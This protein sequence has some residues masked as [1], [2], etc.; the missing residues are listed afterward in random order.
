MFEKFARR[1]LHK[2]RSVA[3]R[4]EYRY[5]ILSKISWKIKMLIFVITVTPKSWIDINLNENI[6]NMETVIVNI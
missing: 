6:I 2:Q 1:Y 3:N 4:V 5:N